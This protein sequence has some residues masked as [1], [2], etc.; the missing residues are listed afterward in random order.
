MEFLN[1]LPNDLIYIVPGSLFLFFGWVCYK[2]SIK[3]IGYFIG[4]LLGYLFIT[5]F[6]IEK[7]I[8]EF[9]AIGF[10][11]IL[12]G[13]VF[14]EFV[15]QMRRL[16]LILSGVFAGLFIMRWFGLLQLF[17]KMEQQLIFSLVF[18][19]LCCA[20]FVFLEKYL[21]IFL[22][23]LCGAS[24]LMHFWLKTSPSWMMLFLCVLGVVAQLII[25]QKSKIQLKDEDSGD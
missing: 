16:Y 17:D 24:L 15:W 3:S 19:I 13:Y 25:T 22:S 6:G 23:S 9:I 1:S 21:I 5:L 14:G 12:L 8:Y 18:I 7:P 10:L 11:S 2:I 4:F 20:F